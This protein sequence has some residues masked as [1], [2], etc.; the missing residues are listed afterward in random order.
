MIN[1]WEYEINT[2]VEVMRTN[3]IATRTDNINSYWSMITGIQYIHSP[4]GEEKKL[5]VICQTIDTNNGIVLSNSSQTININ[6]CYN[7]NQVMK[8][9]AELPSRRV[10]WDYAGMTPDKY[11]YLESR[12]KMLIDSYTRA[13]TIVDRYIKG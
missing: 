8:L 1:D 9:F 3:T 2:I 6:A 7:Y 11:Q 5:Y 13:Q 4:R 10:L 12:L